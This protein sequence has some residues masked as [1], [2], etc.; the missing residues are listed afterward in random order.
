MRNATTG[1][2]NGVSPLIWNAQGGGFSAGWIVSGIFYT[3]S[4]AAFINCF[5][6]G[7]DN[8]LNLILGGPSEGCCPTNLPFPVTCA[9]VT[10]TI[11]GESFVAHTENY[12]YGSDVPPPTFVFS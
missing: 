11:N 12:G 10:Y 8:A 9:D 2:C 6:M 5:A 7:G 4:L 1:T 3:A